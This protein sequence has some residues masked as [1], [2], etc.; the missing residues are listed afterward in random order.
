MENDGT[1]YLGAEATHRA[2]AIAARLGDDVVA[3]LQ[4]HCKGQ[5][6]HP[7]SHRVKSQASSLR[8]ELL[9]PYQY[10]QD[11]QIRQNLGRDS[12][13]IRVKTE[14]GD[15]VDIEYKSEYQLKHERESR[16]KSPAKNRIQAE[17]DAK[18]QRIYDLRRMTNQAMEEALRPKKRSPFDDGLKSG[19]R[20]N[21]SRDPEWIPSSMHGDEVIN[22][23]VTITYV[24]LIDLL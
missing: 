21:C 18:Q 4:N 16:K 19:H 5:E 20:C 11:V 8:D 10:D 15:E 13:V 17:V 22:Y 6:K 3:F 23:F 7:A 24:K 12:K 1:N 2:D 9:T 14:D